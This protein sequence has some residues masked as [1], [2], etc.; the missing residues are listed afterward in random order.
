MIVYYVNNIIIIIMI[1]DYVHLHVI[2]HMKKLKG[3]VKVV[4]EMFA[5]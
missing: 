2:N 1:L 4:G 3:Y 5:H